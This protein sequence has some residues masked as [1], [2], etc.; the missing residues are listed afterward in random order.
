MPEAEARELARHR[1]TMA[2][3]L[4]VG[5]IEKVACELLDGVTLLI[6]R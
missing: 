5:M 4:S 6:P 3:F 2:I 1:A